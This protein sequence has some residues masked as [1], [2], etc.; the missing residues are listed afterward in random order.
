MGGVAVES[1]DAPGSAMSTIQY[2][3]KRASQVGVHPALHLRRVLPPAR[4]V[5]HTVGEEEDGDG[6]GG[7]GLQS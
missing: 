2:A 5:L 3:P 4:C 7:S 1:W 6:E